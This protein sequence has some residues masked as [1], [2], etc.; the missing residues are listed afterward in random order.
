MILYVCIAYMHD[1][2]Y[3]VCLYIYIYMPTNIHIHI[4]TYGY[5]IYIEDIHDF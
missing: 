5:M 1:I 4:Y 3:N 2:I